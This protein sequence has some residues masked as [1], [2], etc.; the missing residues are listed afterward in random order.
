MSPQ[1]LRHDRLGQ[2]AQDSTVV[3]GDRV[4]GAALHAEP[5]DRALD[6]ERLQLLRRELLQS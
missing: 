2:R 5:H 4:H 1:L 6:Q 3:G